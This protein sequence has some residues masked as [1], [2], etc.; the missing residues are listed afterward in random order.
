M[1]Q[2]ERLQPPADIVPVL[3]LERGTD[4]SRSYPIAF[5]YLIETAT[6]TDIAF[7]ERLAEHR[8]FLKPLPTNLIETG[9]LNI[10]GPTE[11]IS[12]LE[13]L[14]YP[15]EI[16]HLQQALRKLDTF[17]P[18]T[19]TH[20]I[21]VAALSQAIAERLGFSPQEAQTIYFEGLAHD[22]GK[23]LIKD[24]IIN[25]PDSLT[26]DEFAAVKL[27]TELGS[28]LVAK[29]V[30]HPIIKNR[31]LRTTL[32]HHANFDGNGYPEH[33]SLD[34]N[35]PFTSHIRIIS[36]ADAVDAM[37][38]NRPYKT[39]YSPSQVIIEL[40]KGSGSQFEPQIATCTVDLIRTSLMI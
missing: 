39:A 18:H 27:H 6:Q 5:P 34:P 1:I 35:H 32:F 23:A 9:E 16:S 15:A 7:I 26:E 25:K 12:P 29:H 37:L 33:Y 14:A 38:K 28:R 24:Q 2:G 10:D 17:S 13:M 8:R 21:H 36:T 30:S 40:E 19:R 20:E 22:I 11:P 4:L 3:H 31:L